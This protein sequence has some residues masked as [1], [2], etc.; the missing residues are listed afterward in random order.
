[1]NENRMISAPNRAFPPVVLGL[2]IA[3]GLF[4][5]LQ[6]NAPY[7]LT[8][9]ALWP[10]GTPDQAM[11]A[12]GLVD[13]PQFHIWQLVSYGF[14]H[15][16]TSHLFFNMLALWMFG[17]ALE[18]TW[19]SVRFA[20]FYFICVVGA[21]VVQLITVSIDAAQG[22]GIYPTVGASGG[23]YG[24]LLGFGMLF[25]NRIIVLLIPPIPMKA[26]YFVIVFGLIEL[27]M[28]VTGTQSG[29]AHFAHLGGML[30]GLLL[31]LYWRH[32][33]RQNSNYTIPF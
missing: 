25:P 17:N 3:N 11:S 21:G 28:G 12:R 10:A 14:L 8:P 2:L 6:S 26:K 5:F 23:V 27:V 18:N 7:L 13:V 33:E 1:M 30:F 24:I 15:G 16:G 32:K 4:F 22:S 31:I 9:L 29:V 20:M 19:G